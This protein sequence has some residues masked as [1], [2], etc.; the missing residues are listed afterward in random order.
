MEREGVCRHVGSRVLECGGDVGGFCDVAG[1]AG[2]V[3]G[4]GGGECGG[5]AGGGVGRGWAVD[6]KVEV[7]ACGA[8]LCDVVGYRTMEILRELGS[9]NFPRGG[10][11][12]MTADDL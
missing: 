2:V 4:A 6:G 5:G 3:G 10:R 1:E 8:V 9:Q 7:W 12:E 11:P